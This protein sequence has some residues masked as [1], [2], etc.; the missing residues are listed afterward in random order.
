M[1][2]P[3]DI[4]T[5]TDIE[6]LVNAFYDQVRKDEVIGPI[7]DVVADWDEHLPTLY[8]F[9]DSVLLGAGTYKGAPF[10]KHAVLPLRQAH[11]ERWLRLFIEAVDTH[12][13]GPKSE[14]AKDRAVS[15]ADT[16][17]RR[18]GVLDDPFAL[19]RWRFPADAS[20]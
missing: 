9:W 2:A 15:I 13:S 6:I 4:G 14:E 16:F 19:T 12:F 1:H 7:F 8:R 3:Q 20:H 17:A 18:M 5:T 10:P 11:F